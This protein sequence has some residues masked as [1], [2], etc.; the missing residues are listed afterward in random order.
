[1]PATREMVS[2]TAIAVKR[3]WRWR[4]A[5]CWTAQGIEEESPAKIDVNGQ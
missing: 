4:I 3:S 2:I 5:A 1:M